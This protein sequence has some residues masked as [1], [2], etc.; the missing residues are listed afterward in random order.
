MGW[1]SV[2]MIELSPTDPDPGRGGL[3]SVL[4]MKNPVMPEHEGQVCHDDRMV[5]NDVRLGEIRN[6][7]LSTAPMIN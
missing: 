5:G 1:L 2:R 7:C 3:L 4:V 6:R